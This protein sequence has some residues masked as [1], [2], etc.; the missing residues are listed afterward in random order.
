MYTIRFATEQD[1]PVLRGIYAPY[2][3]QTT[4]TF[5]YEVPSVEEFAG[6]I[7]H[8]AAAY[9]YLLC[10]GEGGVAGYAYAC[11]YGSRAA[12]QWDAEASIYLRMDCRG[13]G[14]G[15]AL[16]HAL[17]ALLEEQGVRNVYAC[18][19]RPNPASEGLH[20]KMGF[21][22]IGLFPASGFKMNRWIDVAWLQ[23]KLGQGEPAG[24]VLFVSQLGEGKL[25]AALR[26]AAG[27]VTRQQ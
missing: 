16:Y 24:P 21:E 5:E 11:R 6:R 7:R 25:Q 23:K 22:P 13:Q 8:I 10:E 3:T 12:Y 20:R 1:A 19:T 2:V 14:V 15:S 26:Q 27:S 17:L 4:I 18:V 9:P